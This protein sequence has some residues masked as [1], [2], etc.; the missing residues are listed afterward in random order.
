MVEE[1]FRFLAPERGGALLDLT[2]GLGGHSL[3][4]LERAPPDARV[5]GVDADP[6]A[7][8]R[9]R[10]RLAPF[11]ARADLVHASLRRVV[12]VARERAWPRPRAAILDLGL[13][14]LQIE[15][16]AR[17]FSYRREGP[18]D[19]RFDP[20]DDARPTAAQLLLTTPRRELARQLRELGDEEHADDIAAAIKASLPIETTTQLAKIV[21]DAYG[22]RFAKVHPAR[23]VFQVLRILVNDEIEA[24]DEGLRGAIDLLEPGGRVAVISFH[25][26]EDRRVKATLK[27]LARAGTVELL[28]RRPV[29]P[30]FDERVEN[31][32]ARSAKLRAAEK[33]A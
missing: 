10:T 9:A 20:T 29:R 27:E 5:L 13:S 4:W 28:T 23:R 11:G 24:L 25:S 17:G 14:S 26:G 3:A 30:A 8:E 21:K 6:H 22:Q 1:A 16:D 32:R 7:V 18:L 33:R 12:E 19:M 31:Q 15:D 2:L